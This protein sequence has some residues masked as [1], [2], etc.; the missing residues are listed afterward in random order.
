MSKYNFIYEKLVTSDD[1]LVGLITYGIYKKQKI[2]S[3]AKI[4]E[5]EKKRAYRL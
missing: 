4:K 5:T 1:D 2:E 3:I